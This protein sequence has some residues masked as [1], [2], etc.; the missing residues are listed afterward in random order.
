MLGGAFAERIAMPSDRVVLVPDSIPTD[1]AV[2]LEPLA[3]AAHAM[4]LVA[5]APGERFVAV[6]P[7]PFALLMCQIAR[8]SGAASVVAVGLEGVDESRLEIARRVGADA[9]VLH[10]GDVGATAGAIRELTGGAGGDVVMDCGGTPESTSLALEAAAAG[11]RVGVFGFTREA[12]IEPLRQIIRKGLTLRGV[13]AAQRRHYGAALR[14]IETG[15]VEPSAIVTHRLHLSRAAE[16]IELASSRA[17]A[18]VLLD[19]T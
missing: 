5:V 18:K 11:A 19:V 16:G 7:G 14:L 2:L 3:V 13:S 1:D 17:A 12:R 10:S 9:T 6:G 4:E 15:T 8:A